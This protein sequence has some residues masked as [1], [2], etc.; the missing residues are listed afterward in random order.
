M[1]AVTVNGEA[2]ALKPGQTVA[3]L[4]AALGLAPD[5]VAVAIN[6]QVVPRSAH[7]S[8]ALAAG[9]RIEIIRAVGGG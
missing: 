1:I 4:V 8:R 7:R 9:D 6:L 2:R 5:G 3:D